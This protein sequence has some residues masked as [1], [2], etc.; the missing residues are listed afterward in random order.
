MTMI[1]GPISS[2]RTLGQPATRRAPL[3]LLAGVLGRCAAVILLVTGCGISPDDEPRALPADLTGPT[4]D[5]NLEDDTGNVPTSIF[6]QAG[7]SRRL[8]PVAREVN[9]LS[10]QDIARA[11]LVK[12]TPTEVAAGISTAIPPNTRLLSGSVRA[13]GVIAINLSKEFAQVDGSSRTTAVG[14]IVLGVGSQYEPDRQFSFLIAGES[15]RISTAGG[16]KSRVTSCDFSEALAEASQLEPDVRQQA[17][18][19]ALVA[20]NNSLRTRCPVQTGG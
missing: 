2:R 10:V 9:A 13:D 1:S 20:E 14:Q 16:T 19:V 5:R 3:R 11:T 18:L 4:R 6:M 8:V 12:P 17:D 7:E 15:A